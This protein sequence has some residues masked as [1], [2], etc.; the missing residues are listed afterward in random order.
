MSNSSTT[1]KLRQVPGGILHVGID[2]G[3]EK[4]W[5]VMINERAERVD[6]FS[7]SSDRGSYNYFLERMEKVCQKQQAAG[8][9]VAMEPTNYF[10][11]LL[12]QELEGQEM[13]Y[14]LVNA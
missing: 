11:K 7:F 9:Q 13:P 12:A 2:L 10:W 1:K 14:H 6:R 5:A 3:L 8:I 4:N